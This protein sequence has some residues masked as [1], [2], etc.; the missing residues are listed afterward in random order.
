[1]TLINKSWLKSEVLRLWL[2]G[3][4]QEAIANQLNISVGTVNSIVDEIMKSD[5][6]I[7][8]Q[9]QIAIVVKKN[10]VKIKDIAANLRLKNLIKQSSLD[11]K[12]VEKFLDAMDL[13][14]NK[15][16][17]PPSAAANQFFSIIETMLRE[18]K[19]PHKLEEELKSKTS[20][21]RVIDSQIEITNK[22][23]EET[24]A[25]A[26][27]EQERL[28]INQKDLDQ[29]RQISQ[30]LELREYPEFSPKYGTVARALADMK[31]MGYDPKIIV[32]KYEDFESLVKANQKLKEKNLEAEEMLRNYKHK[33]DEEKASLK[34]RGNSFEIF[35]R[36]I[37]DGLKDEDIFMA[38]NILKND[39][40][41]SGIEQ[42][43]E[44]IRTYGNISAAKWKLKR[45][46]EEES[47]SEFPL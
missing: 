18:N 44:D 33:L 24:K 1:M 5:D 20:E 28:K 31:E 39:Y 36:L 15:Y 9:R 21:L 11:D 25:R 26:K 34:D 12:K 10:G 4:S 3:D 46:Y 23:L 47:G 13:L 41:Q 17:I 16:S 38:V 42:L 37:K 22:L 45:E 19:E 35:T 43:I 27:E 8:L 40:P 29:F 30:L 2:S 7:D 32:S 14:C 6:T